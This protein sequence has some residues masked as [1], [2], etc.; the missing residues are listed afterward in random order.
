MGSEAYKVALS[1]PLDL[2]KAQCMRAHWGSHMLP[3]TEVSREA[4][5]LGARVNW[6]FSL[7]NF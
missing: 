5:G 2:S 1:G 6:F 3:T 7:Q 4:P